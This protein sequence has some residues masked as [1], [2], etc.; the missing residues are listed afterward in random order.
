MG[1]YGW[2]YQEE[3]GSPLAPDTPLSDLPRILR[4]GAQQRWGVL[5]G[6]VLISH[7]SFAGFGSVGRA[8]VE[9]LSNISAEVLLPP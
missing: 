1:V 6:G 8:H 9:H 5:R 7:F 4:G 2:T 3:V